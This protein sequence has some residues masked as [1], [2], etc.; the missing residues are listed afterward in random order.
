MEFLKQCASLKK[1]LPKHYF[2]SLLK[3]LSNKDL[4]ILCGL[5]ATKIGKPKRRL[6]A[7]LGKQG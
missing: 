5:L 4:V 7:T 3:D 2:T 6:Y 1:S